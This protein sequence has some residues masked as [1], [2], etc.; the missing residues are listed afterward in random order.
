M[1]SNFKFETDSILG[2]TIFIHIDL[3]NIDDYVEV[4]CIF[5]AEENCD[6]DSYPFNNCLIKT[7]GGVFK[8]I[9]SSKCYSLT[10]TIKLYF[11]ISLDVE[12]F[13]SENI[14]YI[15]NSTYSNNISNIYFYSSTVY[16]C[17][18]VDNIL[19]FLTL[20][21]KEFIHYSPFFKCM[22]KLVDLPKY[23]LTYNEELEYRNLKRYV[24]LKVLNRYDVSFI[25]R[26]IIFI[27][28]FV[29]FQYC[30]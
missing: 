5:D 14:N 1:C 16:G 10:S 28:Y 23:L 25:I 20:Y 3:Y 2:H 29:S 21:F 13:L 11:D 24:S 7:G 12:I 26:S 9:Y 4:E 6:E 17:R 22:N 19:N 15:L 30:I 18:G 8:K 27:K